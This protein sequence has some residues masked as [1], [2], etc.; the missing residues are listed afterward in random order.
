[1]RKTLAAIGLGV[2][3]GVVSTLAVS[4]VIADRYEYV[5]IPVDRC[6]SVQMHA[7]VVPNQPNPCHF[8]TRRW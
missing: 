6:Q 2:V 3:L 4:E 7:E 8:R 1:M 5:T